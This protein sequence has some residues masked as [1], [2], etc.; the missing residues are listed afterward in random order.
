MEVGD[1]VIYRE[2]QGLVNE[3]RGTVAA[4]DRNMVL[5][6]P[7]EPTPFVDGPDAMAFE[8]IDDRMY[9]PETNTIGYGLRQALEDDGIEVKGHL[10]DVRERKFILDHPMRIQEIKAFC[11]R[12]HPNTP[13][14]WMHGIVL[15]AIPIDKKSRFFG[16]FEVA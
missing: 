14:C 15:T 12:K 6:E 1:H 7:D 3:W 5:L 2:P 4:I 10:E 13:Q 8:A 11:K 9:L 16:T